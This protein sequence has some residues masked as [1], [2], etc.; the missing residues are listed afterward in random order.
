[1]IEKIEN[2]FF[3][4]FWEMQEHQMEKKAEGDNVQ[5]LMS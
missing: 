3:T 4:Q 2:L 5:L 1:M